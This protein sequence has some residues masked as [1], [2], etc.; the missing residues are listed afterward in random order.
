MK[1]CMIWDLPKIRKKTY[2]FHA[3]MTFSWNPIQ[4]SFFIKLIIMKSNSVI[5]LIK[6]ILR[7]SNSVIMHEFFSDMMQFYTLHAFSAQ[8]HP[9]LP[10][11]LCSLYMKYTYDIIDPNKIITVSNSQHGLKFIYKYF[12]KRPICVKK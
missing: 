8:N 3:K 4:S 5:I 11:S 2:P 10:T 12:C 7:K 1:L 9:H 6:S